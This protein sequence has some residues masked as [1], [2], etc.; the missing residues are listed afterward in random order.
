MNHL[1]IKSLCSV[2]F[3][4]LS[5]TVLSLFLI[6]TSQTA[7]AQ[8]NEGIQIARV[9]YRGGGD[10]YNDPSALTN[11]LEYANANLPVHLSTEYEDIDIGDP[12][13]HTFPFAFLTGHGT[14][15]VNDTEVRNLRDYLV[16]GGFLFIDDDYGLDKYVR[17]LLKQTFPDEELI[18]LPF[19]H[20]IYH[21]RYDF[22][23]GLPKVHEHDKKPPQGFGILLEGRLAVFY[24]YESNLADGWA[25]PEVHKDPAEV[26]Q[27]ALQMGTNILLYALTQ[28]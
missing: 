17:S 23:K 22:N 21:M 9:K 1:I 5:I 28:L 10:W 2:R 8:S 25:N 3:Y 24:A 13:L 11:L 12:K 14:I 20:A 6:P 26:R 18:E 19:D 27:A 15:K 16:N 4:L 7:I